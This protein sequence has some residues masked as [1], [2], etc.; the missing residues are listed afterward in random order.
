MSIRTRLAASFVTLFA[1]AL[2]A[3]CETG[4][5]VKSEAPAPQ[6]VAV[7]PQ[8][9]KPGL[10][11]LPKG[12]SVITIDE[13]KA[14][15][16]KGPEAG[17]YLMFDS[18]PASRF[19]SGTIPTSLMLPS[20]EQEKLDKEGKA[21]ALLG[22]DKNKLLVFW[23]GGPTCPFSIKGA[24]LAIK[25]GYT[26]VKVFSGGDPAWTKAEQPFVSSPKF[27]KDDNILLIDLRSA[28]K[29]AA[30]HIPRALS[31][32]AA[33]LDKY[34]EENWPSFKGAPLVFYS[35]NQADVDKAL[36]LM[37]DY[38]LS[39]ATYFPGGLER[40]KKLGYQ[41]ET[42]PKAAP[43]KLTFI[44]KLAPQ[45][46]AIPDFIKLLDDPNVVVLDVRGASERTTGQFKGALNIPFE[47]I[48]TRYKEIPK[49]KT[50]IIH[51]ATGIRSS[52]AYET[53]KAKGFTNLKVLNA[54]VK[55]ENGKYKITE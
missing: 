44:R 33:N 50:V 49:D 55:F 5:E 47:E 7:A 52:I 2:L 26:N 32:P 39:K 38:G 51:C 9:A 36:E 41:V 42:G 22:A 16:A 14:L 28:D 17:N 31:L 23:C 30:G 4:P 10:P 3:G 46:I 27:V 15:V 37:R 19:H 21:P 25:Y 11:A 18:R 12:A 29:F 45:D 34:Q 48:S 13:V 6:T 8:K 54:N 24:E 35:D 43:A 1:V 40:W 20:G 53:L